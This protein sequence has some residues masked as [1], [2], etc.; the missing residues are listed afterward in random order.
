MNGSIDRYKVGFR[1]RGFS[2]KEGEDY[3]DSL[4]Q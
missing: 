3:D 1:T 2:Q 4:F